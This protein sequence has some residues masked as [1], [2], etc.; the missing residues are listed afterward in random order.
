M[1]T[2]TLRYEVRSEQFS[3]IN[4]LCKKPG[5]LDAAQWRTYFEA[6]ASK[7]VVSEYQTCDDHL[8]EIQD[9]LEK[10]ARRYNHLATCKD[11]DCHHQIS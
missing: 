1:T 11:D 8:C 3:H 5:C 7:R 2:T 10:K 4:I 9:F 6:P